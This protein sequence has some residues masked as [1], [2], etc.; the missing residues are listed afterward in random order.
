VAETLNASTVDLDEAAVVLDALDRTGDDLT[1]SKT[2]LLEAGESGD[3]VLFN[4]GALAERELD[5]RGDLVDAAGKE[6]SGKEGR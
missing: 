5:L 3:G 1:L 6:R 2:G 4:N